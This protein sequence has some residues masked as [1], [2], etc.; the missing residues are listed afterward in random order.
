MLT[1]WQSRTGINL[2]GD[3]EQ[4]KAVYN[5]LNAG[6]TANE[7]ESVIDAACDLARRGEWQGRGPWP[8]PSEIFGERWQL[9]SAF[10]KE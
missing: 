1:F 9:F 5:R 6:A 10:A 2:V 8:L 3:K 4:R 7:M